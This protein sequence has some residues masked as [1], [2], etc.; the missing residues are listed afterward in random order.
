MKCRHCGA[1]L[2][3]TL[4]G[5]PRLRQRPPI[6]WVDFHY[7]GKPCQCKEAK[8]QRRELQKVS[9]ELTQLI[10]GMFKG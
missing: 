2:Q 9:R 3:Q 10:H 8:R 6:R 4:V 5:S 1:S 7:T